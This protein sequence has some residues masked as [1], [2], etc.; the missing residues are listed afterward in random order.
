VRSRGG[1]FVLLATVCALVAVGAV[2]SAVMAQREAGTAQASKTAQ[3]AP[4]YMVFR[5]LNK[6]AGPA[7]MGELTSTTVGAP[8]RERRAT[9][10]LCER[11]Y[12]SATGGICIARSR[13]LT[14]AYETQLL[15]PEG[16]VRHKIALQGVPSRT[17]VSPDG[18]YGVTTSFVTGDSYAKPGQF[19]TRT[20]LID[21]R[22]GEAIADLETFTVWRSGKVVD[23][24]DVQ[25]WGVTFERKNSDSFY[26]TL[27]TAGK[28]YLIKGSVSAR[29]A[30]TLRENVEC[31]SLSPD[32]TRLGYKKLVSDDGA[33]RFHVLDLQ[34]GADTA[35]A[36]TASVDDQL[37]WLDDGNLL[38]GKGGDIWT[39]P[40]DGSGTPRRFLAHAD[41]PG[42]VSG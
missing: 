31:P 14:G 3:L 13:S 40:A 34:S 11:V 25:F 20:V 6:S 19:S 7:H 26:A 8:G 36:E 32:G 9:G 18:R 10:R 2:V 12:A 41:S 37:E 35:L 28:T 42:V 16:K 33:W 27:A 5:S 23:A 39:V 30:R 15:S 38:Y 24:A 4:P 17:R 1:A 29:T 22:R 21:M